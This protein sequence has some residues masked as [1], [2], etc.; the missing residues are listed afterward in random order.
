MKNTLLRVCGM[1]LLGL[2][3]AGIFVPILPTTPFVLAG[4][5]CL[6]SS[7]PRLLRRLE[8]TRYF[9]EFIQN[10]RQKSGISRRTRIVALCWLWGTLCI[11]ATLAGRLGVKLVL[12]VVG[13][14]VSIHILTI[15][16]GNRDSK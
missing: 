1:L 4:S 14:A 11:S 16:P 5:G 12:L 6:G 8:G 9:G 10:Y 3:F 15:A 2:G 13:I 7:S